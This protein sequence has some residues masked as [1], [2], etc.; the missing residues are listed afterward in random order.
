MKPRMKSWHLARMLEHLPNLGLSFFECSCLV[1]VPFLSA[2]ERRVITKKRTSLLLFLFVRPP[3]FSSFPVVS[4]AFLCRASPWAFLCHKSRSVCRN[5]TIRRIFPFF[6]PNRLTSLSEFDCTYRL[7]RAF[8]VA[9]TYNLLI[10]LRQ[11]TML[12]VQN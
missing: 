10:N 6:L 1:S 12:V 5:V 11:S 7:T 8:T 4:T 9:F 2:K 3:G